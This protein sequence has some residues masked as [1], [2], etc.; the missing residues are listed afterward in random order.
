[1]NKQ[2]LYDHDWSMYLL[3]RD[4]NLN[5][6]CNYGDAT[7]VAIIDSGIDIKH[8]GFKNIKKYISFIDNN[9]NDDLGHG[10]M[11]AGHIA[12]RG[13]IEGLAK[14]SDL[15]IYKIMN[16]NDKSTIN[17]LI[18]ALNQAIAD[19]VDLINLSLGFHI[20]PTLLHTKLINELE[21]S[22]KKAVA[23]GI[24][25][26]SSI[27]YKDDAIHVPSIFKDVI[28]CQTI[29]KNMNLIRKPKADFGVVGGNYENSEDLSELMSIYLP[30]SHKNKLNIPVGYGLYYG[31][32]FSS[33]K[34]TSILSLIVSYIKVNMPS[35]NKIDRRVTALKIIN[36]S[37]SSIN[38]VLIPSMKSLKYNLC[39]N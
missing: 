34:L 21:Y 2:I 20:D 35:M 27:G 24:I 6:L 33:A 23:Q 10:T 22:I 11:I 28:T 31:E 8:P 25:I 7:K 39:L 19:K 4:S 13:I 15:Y 3:K 29:D 9:L 14:N 30:T 36:M 26:I 5:S 18:A 37:S 32:S 1:M 38:S 17:L 12:G 16:L